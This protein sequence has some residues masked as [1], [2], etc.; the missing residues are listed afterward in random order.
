MTNFKALRRALSNTSMDSDNKTRILLVDDAQD[1]T[2]AFRTSLE[3]NGFVVVTLNDPQEEA[4]SNFK[5][6]VY[7]SSLTTMRKSTKNEWI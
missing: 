2:L 3:D 6:G 7:I 4:L 1:I 5:A